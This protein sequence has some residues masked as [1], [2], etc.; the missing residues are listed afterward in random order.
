MT[1][2]HSSLNNMEVYNLKNVLESAGIGCE[3]RGEFRRSAIGELPVGESFIELWVVDDS[4]VEAAKELL[5]AP[6]AEPWTCPNCGE[7]VGSGFGQ[8]WSCQLDRPA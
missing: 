5:D 3:I 4:Q 8:C 1:R 6:P 7:S 2:I